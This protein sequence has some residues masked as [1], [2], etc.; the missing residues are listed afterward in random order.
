MPM[1]GRMDKEDMVHMYNV[2]L[3]SYKKENKIMPF[4]ETWMAL[5]IVIL[6]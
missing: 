3:L 4:A 5:K 2:I 6:S 1:N